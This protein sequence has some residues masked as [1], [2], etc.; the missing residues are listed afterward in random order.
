[1]ARK[2]HNYHQDFNSV[3]DPFAQ[4]DEWLQ[5]AEN[6]ERT[7]ESG[8]SKGIWLSSMFRIALLSIL[9]LT[10][11]T[12]V[13][14]QSWTVLF[15]SQKTSPAVKQPS[16]DGQPKNEENTNL[17][18]VPQPAFLRG[19]LPKVVHSLSIKNVD[20]SKGRYK[21]IA[22]AEDFADSQIGLVEVKAGKS[23][24]VW[25]SAKTEWY[26]PQIKILPGCKCN[27][28][29]VFLVFWQGGAAW[30]WV[31]PVYVEGQTVHM[32]HS[33]DQEIFE[34]CAF[35]DHTHRLVGYHRQFFPEMFEKPTIYA[36]TGCTFD[37]DK[38]PHRKLYEWLSKERKDI[39][40]EFDPDDAELGDAEQLTAAGHN[41]LALKILSRI[42]NNLA[43]NHSAQVMQRCA[44]LMNDQGKK[45]DAVRLALTERKVILARFIHITKGDF[46]S[47][48]ETAYDCAGLLAENGKKA[49]AISLLQATRR[50]ERRVHKEGSHLSIGIGD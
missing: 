14:L 43:K 40:G 4:E 31:Q 6:D 28:H 11:C 32:L 15:H 10:F 9:T 1:M 45:I 21:L 27:G 19:L 39:F 47:V 8:S 44:E 7:S 17:L 50:T 24:I 48:S 13:V 16:V 2:R 18:P 35:P 22:W 34:V 26:H 20:E 41:E 37:F 25:Q 46:S 29:Q 36:W 3:S 49:E 30:Q 38:S 33:F 5:A 23:R 12:W 42:K